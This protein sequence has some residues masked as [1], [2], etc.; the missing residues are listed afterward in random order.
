MNQKLLSSGS[1]LSQS[2]FSR[3]IKGA[4][5]SV[6]NCIPWRRRLQLVKKVQRIVFMRHPITIDGSV[7]PYLFVPMPVSL[8]V[9]LS[10]RTSAHLSIYQLSNNNNSASR[11]QRNKN[12]N[13][14]NNTSN[15]GY[16]RTKRQTPGLCELYVMVKSGCRWPGQNG[17][18]VKFSP[19]FYRTLSPSGQLPCLNFSI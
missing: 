11:N 8:S 12:N 5:E 6:V 13:V 18:L 15:Y 10:F 17:W 2:W 14:N 16:G 4:L 1:Q 7:G 19:L 3:Y 9:C